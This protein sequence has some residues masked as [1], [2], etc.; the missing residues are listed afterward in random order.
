V[1]GQH[2]KP[3]SVTKAITGSAGYKAWMDGADSTGRMALPMTVKDLL[4]STSVSG[5]PP[6][7]TPYDTA[8]PRLDGLYANP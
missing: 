5:S 6:N 4:S 2:T 3:V 8:T 1:Q 7:G